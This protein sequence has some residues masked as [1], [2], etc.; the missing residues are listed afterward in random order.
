MTTDGVSWKLD[1]NALFKSQA[2]VSHFNNIPALAGGG[3]LVPRLGPI[4]HDARFVEWMRTPAMK[5]FRKLWGR[6][7]GV[8]LPAGT[9][10]SVA[11][12]NEWNSYGFKGAKRVVLSTGSWVRA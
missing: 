12:T 3:Q 10:I 6:I 8:T 5:D 4:G 9:V 1:R 11:I 7:D 2:N